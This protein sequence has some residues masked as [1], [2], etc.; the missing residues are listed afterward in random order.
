MSS[1]L[2]MRGIVKVFPGVRA[3]SGVDFTARAGEIHTLMGENGAGKSTLVKVTTG[4]YPRDGGTIIFDGAPANPASPKEAESLG[5]S[6]VYQEINLIPYLS[7]AE[8]ITLGRQPKR[9]GFLDWRAIRSRAE[10]ALA[11]LE[12]KLDV[13][14][15]L[16][17]CSVAIQQMV[18]IARA[19]D[20]QAKLLILDEPTSS[21]DEREVAELFGIMRKLR[22]E[23]M[24]IIFITHFLDQV[25]QVSDRIT[26]LRNGELVGE[27]DAASLP[28][29]ALIGKMLG[30]EPSEIEAM[31]P[32]GKA[33]KADE[34]RKTFLD[35]RGIGRTGVI[36]PLDM[37]I[38]EGEVLGLAGLLGSGRTE[39]ARMLFG[40]NRPDT[41]TIRIQDR[42]AVLTS[43]AKAIAHGIAFCSEDRKS[44]GIIP[45]LSVRENIILAMQANRGAL[46]TLPR[47]E[48]LRIADHY[49]QALGIKT[50]SPETPISSLSGGNQQKVLLARWLAM[51]PKL[52]ILDEPTRGI[53][54]GAKAEIEKLVNAL[55]EQGMAILF[56]SSE[57]EE[58]VRTS[59]RVIVLRD[60]KKIGELT[61]E[62]IDE[63]GIMRMIAG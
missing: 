24:G 55:R 14:Q 9:F 57:L 31:A 3:L 15:E 41:G 7:I 2:E 38:A 23:G 28:R 6:T 19:L 47:G 50:P 32:A 43:P 35:A 60:R 61:G 30:K 37:R 27:F 51:Q 56:I 11:R 52:I 45:N 40:I 4:V 54:V 17:S 1:L 16:G 44:E 36:A 25:Y 39:T 22:G 59:Q 13:G 18:A 5:I 26:V 46:R 48:Q 29:L 12:M 58:V 63:H 33:A 62:E 10:E 21:L 34:G 8:N 20:V 53:D 42:P 49:I